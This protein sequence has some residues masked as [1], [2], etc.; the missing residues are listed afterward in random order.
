MVW[1][2]QVSSI[3]GFTP[4]RM[5]KIVF[6]GVDTTHLRPY[7]IAQMGIGLI[8]QGRRIFTSLTV[9]E[10]LQ[11]PA[12]CKRGGRVWNMNSILSMFPLLRERLNHQG[13]ELSGGEQ[14]M[15]AIGRALISNPNFL[16]NAGH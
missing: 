14:Q 2:G 6:E 15:L 4:P 9:E 3:L 10:N 11:I 7:R 13:N 12:Q 16:L 5:G 1:G 8:P